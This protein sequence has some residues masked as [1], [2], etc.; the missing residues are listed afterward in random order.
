LAEVDDGLRGGRGRKEFEPQQPF[1]SRSTSST[2][3]PSRSTGRLPPPQAFSY[4]KDRAR[5]RSRENFRSLGEPWPRPSPGPTSR[6]GPERR[7]YFRILPVLSGRFATQ[8]ESVE[9]EDDFEALRKAG[10]AE[11]GYFR[12]RRSSRAT[13]RSPFSIAFVAAS[14]ALLSASRK[15]RWNSSRSSVYR[16]RSA[17]SSSRRS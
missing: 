2:D 6:S 10:T 13:L 8:L 17:S 16:A 7:T 4:V 14:S 11:G 3:P 9:T 1:G 12:C 5:R 15:R